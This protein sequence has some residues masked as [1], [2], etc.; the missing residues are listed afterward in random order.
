L[1]VADKVFTVRGQGHGETKCTF[2][3]E[4]T[5]HTFGRCGGQAH[6]F[7]Y[8]TAPAAPNSLFIHC[9]LLTHL[10]RGSRKCDTSLVANFIK[11][12]TVKELKIDQH[13]SRWHVF[14]DS[15]CI[16]LCCQTLC[17]SAK[18][19]LWWRNLAGSTSCCE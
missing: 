3:A 4:A 19:D 18:K 12:T 9:G 1:G 2:E 15:Q 10:R 13:L 8:Y 16:S 7:D 17:P 11:S 5:R 6:L 14:F